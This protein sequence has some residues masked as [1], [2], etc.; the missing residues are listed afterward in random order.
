MWQV[1]DELNDLEK[2]AR[3]RESRVSEVQNRLEESQ[4][5]RCT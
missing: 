2:S 1:E 3:D 4:V 5:M